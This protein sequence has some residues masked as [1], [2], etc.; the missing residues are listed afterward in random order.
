MPE[1]FLLP[2]IVAIIGGLGASAVRL[3]PLVGFLGAGF[4]LSAMGFEHIPAV[5]EL[6]EVGVAILLFTIGLHLDI[7]T[8]TKVRIVGTAVGHAALNI[9]VY[10]VILAGLSFLPF[11]LFAGTGIAAFLLIGLASSFSSTVF[12]MALLEDSGR[13]RSRVGQIAV[14]VLVLQDVL[15]VVFLVLASGKTPQPWAYLLLLLPLIRPVVR[16]LPDRVYRMELLV[17]AGVTIAIGAYALFELAGLSGTF[18]ALVMGLVLA[19]HPIAGRLFKGL[20]SVRELLLVGFFIEIGLGGIPDLG[21]FIAAGI[22]LAL[23]PLKA[24]MFV[25]VL[26][27]VGM[28]RRT[29]VLTAGALANYS[30]FGLIVATLAAS[31]GMLD[32]SWVQVMAL[33]VAGSFVLSAI[34]SL[35]MDVFF[36]RLVEMLPARDPS[37][38]AAGERP[39]EIGGVDAIILGMGRVGAGAYKQLTEKYGLT[40]AGIEH[41]EDRVRDMRARGYIVF[42]GDAT[43]PE[44]WARMRASQ[45]EPRLLV[46]AMPDHDANLGALNILRAQGST[47]VTAAI[48]KYNFKTQQLSDFGVDASVN[49]YSGAGT[50]LADVA[51]RAMVECESCHFNS[52]DE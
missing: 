13:I 22:L 5:G 38:L 42:Q 1:E 26:Y 4:V 33:A 9:V 24:L 36:E 35:K 31:R 49:L 50:E 30:E 6:G 46:L 37:R 45:H 23:L 21:G 2:A 25:G 10:A 44:L 40:V 3:P 18:G 43:D 34:A 17:L 41:D 29:S 12:V 39:L 51:F 7:S 15:A 11:A 16:R 27:K 32:S 19:G 28:S 48:A 20:T 47:M 8:L 14:G 52:E